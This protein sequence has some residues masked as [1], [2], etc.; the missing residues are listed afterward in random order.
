MPSIKASSVQ[1][2]GIYQQLGLSTRLVVSFIVILDGSWG[3][4][5]SC[6]VLATWSLVR[7][8]FTGLWIFS[9][10]VHL[11]QAQSCESD[12]QQWF[13]SSVSS[14]SGTE[15]RIRQKL[16]VYSHLI[17]LGVK[18]VACP[19]GIANFVRPS[20]RTANICGKYRDLRVLTSRDPSI[21]A[22][23][24]FARLGATCPDVC[25]R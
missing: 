13:S 24:R 6:I 21:R 1:C 9:S 7:S 16:D 4:S 3:R 14:S 8:N 17:R 19:H 23:S 18:Q 10:S 15:L 2:P 5:R 12:V 11:H 22:S 25:N 20:R